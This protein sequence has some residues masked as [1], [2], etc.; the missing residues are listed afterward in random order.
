LKK[1]VIV[2]LIMIVWSV[3]WVYGD[4]NPCFDASILYQAEAFI[5]NNIASA[6]KRPYYI[7]HYCTLEQITICQVDE[8]QVVEG[9]LC[10]YTMQYT[11]KWI[12]LSKE[13]IDKGEY[14][15]PIIYEKAIWLENVSITE[16]INVANTYVPWGDDG[17]FQC[18]AKVL[19]LDVDINVERMTVPDEIISTETVKEQASYAVSLEEFDAQHDDTTYARVNVQDALNVRETPS[20]DAKI[21]TKLFPDTR[22]TIK[23]ISSEHIPWMFIEVPKTGETGWVHGDY[24]K[25]SVREAVLWG[26]RNL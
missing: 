18:L 20:T 16:Q 3:E 1:I 15:E 19:N 12:A 8:V 5:R 9:G 13:K 24:L 25:R 6:T 23:E 14:K 17:A 7:I 21:I 4:Q 26:S 11:G 2:C 10:P 22:V